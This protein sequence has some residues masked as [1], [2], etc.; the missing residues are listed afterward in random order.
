MSIEEFALGQ[1]FVHRLDPRVKILI[2]VLFS[3]VIALNTSTDA[4]LLALLFP[5]ALLVITRVPLRKVAARLA[6]VNVFVLFLW[7]FLPFSVPGEVLWNVGPLA[8]HREGVDQALLI[9]AKSNAIVLALM[10]LLG[11]S[12][13]FNV[14]HALSHLGV[15]DKLVHLFFFSFRYVHVIFEEYQK[16]AKAAK[17]R[18]FRPRTDFH[19]YRTYAYFVGMLL[20]KSFDRSQRIIAAMKCR[21]FKGRFYILHH[22]E[23]K[24]HDY[25]LAASSLAVCAALAFVR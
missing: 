17:I 8:I 3:V 23:M 11:T 25:V 22:Y 14:V 1:S 10:V 18:G 15:P 5:V 7:F 13:V 16:L 20:V 9:T 24:R 19:T 21:G 2:A 12:P 6:V 4:V